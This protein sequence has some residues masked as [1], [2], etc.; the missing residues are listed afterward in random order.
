MRKRIAKVQNIVNNFHEMSQLLV[1]GRHVRKAASLEEN[2]GDSSTS[3]AG[4]KAA[5]RKNQ[6]STVAMDVVHEVLSS[7]SSDDDS[8]DDSQ[9]M[10]NS[11]ANGSAGGM[12]Q[13]DINFKRESLDIPRTSSISSRRRHM[14]M[15]VPGG[16]E[17]TKWLQEYSNFNLQA[18]QESL[19]EHVN[20]LAQDSLKKV[21][22]LSAQD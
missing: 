3:S 2:K 10:T 13:L 15:M 8:S 19:I 17:S 5:F 12:H 22:G 16:R 9:G 1:K 11:D 14:S 4:R 20:Q 21:G 6:V 18:I 7:S